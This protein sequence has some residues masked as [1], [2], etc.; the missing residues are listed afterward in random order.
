MNTFTELVTSYNNI[1]RDELHK[2]KKKNVF[3]LVLNNSFKT[4]EKKTQQ[5]VIMFFFLSKH[6]YNNNYTRLYILTVVICVRKLKLV[7]TENESRGRS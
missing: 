6:S 5:T 1:I 2:K 7:T 4:E 3:F